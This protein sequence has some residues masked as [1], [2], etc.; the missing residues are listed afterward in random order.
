M[1]D[2]ERETAATVAAAWARELPGVPTRSIPVVWAAKTISAE[3]RRARERAL[4]VV[5][6]DA[7]T[8]DLLSTLRRSGDPYVLTTRQLA[9][10]CL[11]SAGA[12]SQ[13]VARAERDGLVTRRP[14]SGRRVEVV[15]SAA[16]HDLVE[17]GAGHVLAVD[18]RL[19]AGLSDA[20]LGRLE[21]LLTRWVEVLPTRDA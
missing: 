12:I 8:L 14:S 9:E 13:R 2:G 7:G 11:V 6:I 19:T 20:D 1:P 10:R 4:A 5:G 17:R 3:L 18:A 16:G 15:L 21:S